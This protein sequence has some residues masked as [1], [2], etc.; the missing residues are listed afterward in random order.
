MIDIRTSAIIRL[1]LAGAVF[2][3]LAACGIGPNGKAMPFNRSVD[4]VHQPVVS[5]TSFTFDVQAG[6]D[7]GL[8][9]AERTR[10][11]EWLTSIKIGYGD[12]VAIASGQ[13]AYGRAMRDG[14]ALVF[15]RRGM[16]IDE[17]ESGLAGTAPT[18]SVRLIVRRAHASVPNCPDW[19]DTAETNG[20]GAASANYGCALNATMAAM[21]ANPDDLVRGQA[22][23]S[24]LRTATSN[25]AIQVYRDKVPTGSA[26]LPTA[27]TGTK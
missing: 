1:A 5:Y 7:G 26:S 18:G 11:N 15:A 10:L 21:V 16:L 3:P 9:P 17:D 25:R 22:T 27:S 8:S 4:S 13:E 20:Q 6:S 2:L 23:N 19:H 12:H 24:D 14:I